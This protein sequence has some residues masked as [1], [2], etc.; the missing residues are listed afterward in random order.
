MTI[1]AWL[2]HKRPS[3]DTSLYL[4]FFTRQQGIVDCLYKGGRTPKKHSM[5][6]AF[7]PLW[8]SMQQRGDWYYAQKIEAKTPDLILTKD[9][10]FAALYV[11]ELIYTVFR[12][13][14]A[15]SVLYDK[16]EQTLEMLAQ[17]FERFGIEII[18]R[19]FEWALL[20]ACG[21]EFSLTHDVDSNPIVSEHFYQWVAGYG[22]KSASSGF[23]G[24]HLLAFAQDQ[25][26]NTTV[27]KTIKALMR[28]A[29]YFVLDGKPIKAREL[30]IRALA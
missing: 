5:L 19:R 3:G 4:S 22:F 29:M 6:Q 12:A 15:H 16:Y 1:D 2:L 8:V 26:D 10:L 13:G 28:Q 24:G 17:A 20:C 30:Y 9:A 27:L 25:L 7:T 11:N 21:Y 18:L 14:D 23:L